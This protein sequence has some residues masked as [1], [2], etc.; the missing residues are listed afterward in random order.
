MG[1][2]AQGAVRRLDRSAANQSPWVGSY[3]S[4]RRTRVLRAS[5]VSLTSTVIAFLIIPLLITTFSAS[6]IPSVPTHSF[7]SCVDDGQAYLS[8][9][10]RNEDGFGCG[11]PCEGLSV[12]VAI[13]RYFVDRGFNS[14]TLWETPCRMR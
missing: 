3:T 1:G 9:A 12:L 8:S 11:C 4:W 14:R 7:A 10:M 5:G 13:P 6:K 2:L